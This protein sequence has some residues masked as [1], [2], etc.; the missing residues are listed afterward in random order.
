[1][2]RNG[3]VGDKVL[4]PQQ[5]TC[6]EVGL[7]FLR[8]F[9]NPDKNFRAW[10]ISRIEEAFRCDPMDRIDL[11]VLRAI[12]VAESRATQGTFEVVIGKNPGVRL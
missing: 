4:L 7:K 11:Q 12:A 10:Q 8:L 3:S 5:E 1:M 9:F 2:Q 6:P